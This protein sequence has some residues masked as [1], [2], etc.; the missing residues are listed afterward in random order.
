[1]KLLLFLAVAWAAPGRGLLE[2]PPAT[3]WESGRALDTVVVK[4]HDDVKGTPRLAG[5]EVRP[6]FEADARVLAQERRKYGTHLAD[7]G[8]YFWVST[9]PGAAPAVADAFNEMDWVELAYLAFLPQPPPSDIP[10]TTPDF[11]ELQ[12][13]LDAAP[14]GFGFGEG[15]RWPG[16]DGSHVTIADIEYGWTADHEDLGQVDPVVGWGWDSGEYA[17]HGTGVLGILVGGDNGYGVMGGAPGASAM[18]ISPFETSEVYSVAA[19]I[20]GATELLDA[21]D[22]ILIEQ[23]SMAHDSYAPVEIEAAVFD[24]IAWAVTKGITVV[25]PSGNGAQDLDAAHWHNAFD[26]RAR[27][28]GA[29]L[30]GGGASP[31]SGYEPR[32]WYPGGSCYGERVDVQG[33]FDGIVTTINTD[34]GGDYA[35][36]WVADTNAHPSGD[37]RQAYTTL[38]GGTSGASP[39]VAAAVAVANSVAIEVRGEPLSPDEVR[40]LMRATGTTQPAD[41]PYPIGPQPN[42]RNMIRYGVLP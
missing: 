14:S 16:G 1:M 17:F 34:L 28:S 22:V 5:T 21:G 15:E 11:T 23:Q 29:I 33:W 27:D 25:E 36:L 19:A 37:P 9:P 7:L 38:F 41:D 20:Y 32:T 18:V 39:Q 42:L 31:V 4:L 2:K 30:V 6:L 35:D 13:W 26:P 10:P 40:D 24:A 3:V 12:V 8:R